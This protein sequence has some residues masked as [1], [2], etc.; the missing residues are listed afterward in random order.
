MMIQA[1]SRGDMGRSASAA[2]ACAL[3]LGCVGPTRVS[4]LPPLGGSSPGTAPVRAIDQAVA[5]PEMDSADS[6]VS[7]DSGL[8]QGEVTLAS[9]LAS[10]FA[11]AGAPF[12]FGVFGVFDED[13]LVGRQG[14]LDRGPSARPGA[15]RHPACPPFLC[16]PVSRPR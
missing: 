1:P 7:E 11:G 10:L 4:M 9:L 2:V 13:R 16:G 6:L 3:W 5:S 15:K 14:Q 8:A 12:I